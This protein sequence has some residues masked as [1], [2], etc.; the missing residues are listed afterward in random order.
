MSAAVV[1]G[2]VLR[3]IVHQVW[4]S[5]LA[6]P[7][8]TH[9][10]AR[11]ASAA[12]E[13]S[14]TLTGDWNGR[15]RLT[16]DRITAEE[17]ATAML[18]LDEGEHVPDEDL[19]DAMGEVVNMVGGN[20]KG[21]LEGSTR[22]GLPEVREPAPAPDETPSLSCLVHW[23]DASVTLEVYAASDGSPVVAV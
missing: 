19:H 17:I 13:A 11:P 23:R 20:L 21:S 18:A 5:L 9:G 8:V 15:V 16:C 12:V 1:D 6:A 10:E 14:I 7:S 2:E 22:L 4:E 3:S